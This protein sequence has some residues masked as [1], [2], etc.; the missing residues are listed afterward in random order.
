MSVISI[1][2]HKYSKDFGYCKATIYLKLQVFFPGTSKRSLRCAE[3]F[4]FERV[5]NAVSFQTSKNQR[6][7]FLT[8][9]KK[10]TGPEGIAHSFLEKTWEKQN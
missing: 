10:K 2:I 6:W 1:E 8:E 3:N 5:E 9:G 7:V 4:V